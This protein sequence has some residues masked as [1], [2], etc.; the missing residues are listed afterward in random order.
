VRAH[1]RAA[2]I[3]ARAR[4]HGDLAAPLPPPTRPLQGRYSIGLLY[5]LLA[6]EVLRLRGTIARSSPWDVSVDLF[7]YRDPEELKAL[8]DEKAAAAAAGG[9]AFE[10]AGEAPAYDA[11]VPAEGFAEPGGFTAEGQQQW[12]GEAAAEGEWGQAVQAPV[13]AAQWVAGAQVTY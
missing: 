7:F 4:A 12:T 5:Y 11:G 8:E 10:S 9:E 13:D 6:R 2:R 3:V 1:R